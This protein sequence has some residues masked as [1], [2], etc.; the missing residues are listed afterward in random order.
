MTKTNGKML[1]SDR[2]CSIADGWTAEA[3]PRTHTDT[4]TGITK[5][6]PLNTLHFPASLPAS[7]PACLLVSHSK[8]TSVDWR[9]ASLL[10]MQGVADWNPNPETGANWMWNLVLSSVPACKFR[11]ITQNYATTIP[12]YILSNSSLNNHSIIRHYTAREAESC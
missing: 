5:W 11:D 7:L 9:A 3:L 8:C 12:L 10:H 1:W 2:F 6:S 4:G